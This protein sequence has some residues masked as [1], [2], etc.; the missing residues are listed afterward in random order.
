MA[1]NQ[2]RLSDICAMLFGMGR[3]STKWT[4]WVNQGA[5]AIFRRVA[6]F[7]I[8]RWKHQVVAAHVFKRLSYI[9]RQFVAGVAKH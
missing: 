1:L 9:R 6:F 4:S 7:A 2:L 8:C 3:L 5:D